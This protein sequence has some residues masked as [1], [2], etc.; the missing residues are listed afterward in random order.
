MEELKVLML[1]KRENIFCDYAEA[2]LN[3][4]FTDKEFLSIRGNVGEHLNDELYWYRPE[5]VISFISPWIV[6]KALLDAAQK[7]ALNFHPGPPAYPGTGCYNFALYEGA[8]EY[9]VTVH[10]MQEKVDTGKIV[11]TSYFDVSP[12]ET[13]ETMKL[14]SMNHLLFCFDKILAC[15]AVDKPLPVSQETWLR[16][17]FTRKEMCALFEIDPN[18]Q[19]EQEI[20]RRIRAA[21]YPSS[22]GA[23]VMAGGRRF[24]LPQENRSPIVK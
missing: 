16:R 23:Y 18:T 17:P 22:T 2:I 19:D 9:G 15:I 3:S 13:V 6:P 5:Y 7:A 21:E 1:S 8:K 12:L 10:H 14:K 24:Y 11:M 4:Y 20:R